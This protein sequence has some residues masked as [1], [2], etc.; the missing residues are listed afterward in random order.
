MVASLPSGSLHCLFCQVWGS[1]VKMKDRGGIQMD[2]TL[3]NRPT[4]TV[5]QPGKAHPG[6]P[7]TRNR[8]AR[9]QGAQGS[10]PSSPPP[11]CRAKYGIRSGGFISLYREWAR[12]TAVREE[13]PPP[14]LGCC[15]EA[16]CHP[17]LQPLSVSE[18]TNVRFPGKQESHVRKSPPTNVLI[19]CYFPNQ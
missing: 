5:R 15:R 19:H 14:S 6:A 3:F 10:A 13:R 11:S 16:P 17:G 7:T 9:A 18:R 2:K 1:A 8:L 4:F 12:K